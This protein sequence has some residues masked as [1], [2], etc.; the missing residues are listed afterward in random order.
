M[1]LIKKADVNTH[2]A[3][4]RLSRLHIVQKLNEAAEIEPPQ[5]DPAVEANSSA[6]VDDFSLNHSAP[7][8][9]VSAKVFPV[10]QGKS[11][12]AKTPR[13]IHS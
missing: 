8:G 3:A 12:V 9:T 11:Q 10:T 13:A 2:F 4:R 1:T 5:V 7:G 6:F